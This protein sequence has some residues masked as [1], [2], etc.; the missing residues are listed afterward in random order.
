M[1]GSSS[2]VFLF[3][4]DNTL[5]DNDRFEGDLTAWLDREIGPGSADRYW[6]AYEEQRR[7]L[8]YADFLGGFER[9][10]DATGRDPR[11][12]PASEFLLE[13]PFAERLYPGALAALAHLAGF[14]PTWLVTDGDGVMQPSKLRRA[15]LWDAVKGR[16]LIYVHKEQMLD[17][18]ERRCPAQHYVMI[19]DKPRVLHAMKQQWHKRLT[20]VLPR[21]GHYALEPA[22]TS[23]Y[24]PADLTIDRIGELAGSDREL[25]GGVHLAPARE[26]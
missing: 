9:C 1:N 12:L 21:Q 16:V 23:G 4:V 2:I 11:W 26:K 22:H 5:L 8:D 17:D 24:P 14:G 10:W 13:Y 19:D 25:F 7:K 18:I 3:D 15:G 6:A 20:T